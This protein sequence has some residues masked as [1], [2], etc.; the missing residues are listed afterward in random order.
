MH[1]FEP[2]TDLSLIVPILNE[3]EGI[4]AFLMGLA[5][6]QGGSF[7]VVLCDGGSTD[8]TVQRVSDLIVDFPFPLILVHAEK[9]RAQQMNAGA[10]EATGEY[11]LFLHADSSF[12]DTYALGKA[13]SFL[14]QAER[15]AG[16]ERVAARFSLR[17]QA[18]AEIIPF[19]SYYAECKARLDRCGCTHGDQGF[20]IR[21]S[22]FAMAGPFDQSCLVMEDTRFAETVRSMGS[23]ELIPTELVTSVRRFETEGM[24]ERQVLNMILMALDAV[25]RED[26][27]RELPGI[28]AAQS[29]AGRLRLFPFLN[30]IRLL[31]T[32][33]PYAA[34]IKFWFSVGHYVSMNAWQIPFF[35]D[36]RKNYRNTI[37]VGQGKTTHLEFF[38][39]RWYIFFRSRPMA[40]FAAGLAF[41]SF[42]GFCLLARM[43]DW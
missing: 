31:I 4:E 3:A 43:R 41:F 37:P 38:D 34:R 27:I 8:G 6:Q 26:F 18:K 20:L 35:L 22:F 24:V 9:G 39:R 14:R 17:F 23:W 13:L 36:M 42:R 11:F 2:T 32:R 16:N 15:R 25:G 1:T 40:L 12:P 30:R 21:R 19:S 33:L 5:A 7:Q 29:K 10:C 28:Y